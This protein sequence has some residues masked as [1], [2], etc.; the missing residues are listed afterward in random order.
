MVSHFDRGSNS[1]RHFSTNACLVPICYLHGMAV[2]TVEG[3]GSTK[4]GLHIIQKSLVESHGLQCGFCTPGMVMTMYTLCRNN[5]NPTQGDLE[6]VLEGNLC[7]CTGYRPIL[8]AFKKSCPCGLNLCN[9]ETKTEDV[10]SD[11]KIDVDQTLKKKD[12]TQDVIFPSELKLNTDYADKSVLFTGE[13]YAWARPITLAETFQLMQNYPDA[14]L[15]MGCT[16]IGYQLKNYRLKSDMVI[17]CTNVKELNVLKASDKD[18]EI[19]AAVTFSSLESFLNETMKSA[20]EPQQRGIRSMLSALRWLAIDQVRNIAT[21]GGHVMSKAP[22]H[23]L[24]TFLMAAGAK[25]NFQSKDTKSSWYA[26]DNKFVQNGRG[27]PGSG[28]VLVSIS[29]PMLSEDE[30]LYFFKQP[31]RR[32]MDY[33]IVNTGA[34]VKL[35]SKS[36]EL[37]NLRVC[38]GNIASHPRV[39]SNFG[40]LD[41]TKQ[42]TDDVISGIASIIENEFKTS[43][44]DHLQYKLTLATGFFFK[45]YLR[46]Q[47]DLKVLNGNDRCALEDTINEGFKS[48]Q[49]YDV[50]NKE[51]NIIIH[52]P[53]PHTSAQPITTGEAIFVD[54]IPEFSNELFLAHVLSE[55]AHAKVISIDP[56]PALEL[57]GVVD[58][59]DHKDVP[60]HQTYGMMIKDTKLFADG[61]VL[62]IGQ[63]IGAIL[64][65]SRE[66]ARRASKMVKVTYEELPAVFTIDESI[67]SSSFIPMPYKLERG[68]VDKALQEAEMT[69]EG[70]IE[71][72]SQEHFYLEPHTCLVVPKKEHDEL[73]IYTS[74][75]ALHEVQAEVSL[76]LHIPRH[77]IVT[78]VKRLGGGFGGKASDTVH[79]T[80][81]AAI[82][83]F[84]HGVPVRSTYDRARDLRF[85]GKRH[86]TKTM[87]K[88]GFDKNGKLSVLHA[89]LYCN[90]GWAT[91]SSP[92]VGVWVIMAMSMPYNFPH[93]RVNSTLCKTNIPSNGAMRGFGAPQGTFIREHIITDIAKYLDMDP[94]KIRE[95]NLYKEGETIVHGNTE[96]EEIT[97]STCMDKVKEQSNFESVKA[98]IA[99]FNR[100]K[101]WK[102]RGMAICNVMFPMGYPPIVINQAGALVLIYLDGSVLVSHGGIDMGQGV[103]VKCAQVAATV[104]NVP[105]EKIHIAETSIDKVPNTTESGGSYVA[106]LNAGAI[107]VACETILE[108]LE[109]LKKKKPDATWEELVSSAY[110]ERI[111]LS[112]AGYYTPTGRK[113]Y[114]DIMKNIGPLCEYFTYGTA[115]S[116]VEIDCLT[117]EHRLLRTD[118]VMDVGKSL[119]PAIDVGQIEGGFMMGCGMVTSEYLSL[120]QKG[121]IDQY[122]P[123]NYKVPGIRN[124]PQEFH[125]SLLKEV[126]GGG[127]IYSSKGIGEPP[128]L[129]GACV[130]LA[131]KEAIMAARAD[132]GLNDNY[133]LP[134]PAT[135]DKIRLACA[136]P[137][138]KKHHDINEIK[139]ILTTISSELTIENK[140]EHRRTHSKLEV[141]PSAQEE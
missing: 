69:L 107:K 15:V 39:I 120:N 72:G 9:Q 19:G 125:V 49:Y 106:D 11:E 62:F 59:I 108:R 50:P 70:E 6:R 77:K 38:F 32:G 126:K 7:R 115:C 118:I 5:P 140:I 129:L 67:K 98:E 42:W 60:G 97:L 61:E 12:G 43:E 85:T 33:A 76:F 74:S 83:A 89:D 116:Q 3:V 86:G 109:P 73:E 65:T 82:A 138:S 78:K 96:I 4:N 84:K 130:H 1:V 26:Y 128:L 119:N 99:E 134:C 54:D 29:V 35:K 112:A 34:Y 56:T 66:L 91:D 36:R 51:G 88:A 122:G 28:E 123:V 101:K 104:L 17:C 24:Q 95:I 10:K 79:N 40:T 46:L 135:P 37:E 100:S 57:P 81:V 53:T 18:L 64:A 114:H 102:K 45:F 124:I 14:T 41:F 93:F 13:K 136:D 121:F 8:D 90:A 80:G 92:F 31:H 48:G 117:G 87:Y 23:D 141:G 52:Q 44:T 25:L 111:S 68:D 21:I 133:R 58:Y 16:Y 103:H 71:T 2:T 113:N 131:L 94:Q 75:Q 139:K 27:G 105:L 30:Y 22:N 55:K 127:S 63:T 132:H 137:V 110:N 20:K 47:E